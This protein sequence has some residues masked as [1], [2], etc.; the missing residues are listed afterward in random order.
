MSRTKVCCCQKSPPLGENKVFKPIKN[1]I[2][3]AVLDMDN[4][5]QESTSEMFA[6]YGEEVVDETESDEDLYIK[7]LRWV[8]E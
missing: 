2:I 7:S 6:E 8:R 5:V 1:A 3:R 4:L